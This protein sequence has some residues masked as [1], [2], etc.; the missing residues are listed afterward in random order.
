MRRRVCTVLV[1]VLLGVLLACAMPLIAPSPA[2]ASECGGGG[3][4]AGARTSNPQQTCSN[5]AANA[6][7]VVG[8]VAVAIAI[9]VTVLAYRRG[10]RVSE[11]VPPPP[12]QPLWVPE[13]QPAADQSPDHPR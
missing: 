9:G 3:F 11:A 1:G 6:A 10:R 5:Y 7:R 13:P 4:R 2:S 12:E 8:G